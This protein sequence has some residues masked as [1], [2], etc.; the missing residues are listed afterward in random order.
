MT[1]S[2]RFFEFKNNTLNEKRLLKMIS[3]NK[4]VV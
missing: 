4:Q 3:A 1:E 2:R